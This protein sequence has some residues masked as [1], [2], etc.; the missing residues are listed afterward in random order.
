MVKDFLSENRF[1]ELEKLDAD[2]G[3][4]IRSYMN[5][6]GLLDGYSALDDWEVAAHL[7]EGKK[8]DHKSMINDTKGY[9][10]SCRNPPG[11][12]KRSRKKV[13]APTGGVLYKRWTQ[14]AKDY[15]DGVVWQTLQLN[16]AARNLAIKFRM[17][18]AQM[19]SLLGM[20]QSAVQQIMKEEVD[21]AFTTLKDIDTL[22]DTESSAIL[23]MPTPEEIAKEAAIRR[24]Q[25]DTTRRLAKQFDEFQVEYEGKGTD[26]L[27]DY[28]F[29]KK[30]KD[31]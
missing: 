7:L 16:P 29:E 8:P 30:N 12:L 17:Q 21:T 27:S 23:A 19:L 31:K 14:L 18:L 24:R 6:R 15:K 4:E 9:L 26:I 1:D 11:V 5:L 20:A 13:I 2:M 25:R 22:T 28:P 3:T 10:Q